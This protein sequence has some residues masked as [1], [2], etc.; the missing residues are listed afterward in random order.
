VSNESI[1]IGAMRVLMVIPAARTLKDKRR[2]IRSL[3]D[4]LGERFNVSCHLVGHGEQ[5]GKQGL[6][7][8]TGGNDRAHVRQVFD[9]IRAYLNEYDRAWPG[10]IEVETF[11]WHPGTAPMELRDG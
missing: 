10:T 3:T 5:P 9:K 11:S 4:R 1:A 6:V 8:R 2:A 7:L